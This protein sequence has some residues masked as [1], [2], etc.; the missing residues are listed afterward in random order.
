MNEENLIIPEH[1]QKDYHAQ[2]NFLTW[3]R[4]NLTHL[5]GEND[6]ECAL[7]YLRAEKEN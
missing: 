1:L 5:N 2:M 7:R 4:Q 3:V 6:F